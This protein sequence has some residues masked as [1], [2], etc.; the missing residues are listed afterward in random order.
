MHQI[1]PGVAAAGG[2][3]TQQHHQQDD[4]SRH[5]SPHLLR[6]RLRSL[7]HLVGCSSGGENTTCQLPKHQHAW[8]AASGGGGAM[9]DGY[10]A[11]DA[12]R[13]LSYCTVS[14]M[15]TG[16]AVYE[17][18]ACP[19]L[20]GSGATLADLR[21]QRVAV[22]LLRVLLRRVTCGSDFLLPCMHSCAKPRLQQQGVPQYKRATA[23]A[24]GRAATD[25]PASSATGSQYH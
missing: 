15:L 12:G 1:P 5:I 9:P 3:G 11:Q 17:A 22:D 7:V 2:S 19:E 14:S 24:T 6:S 13:S 20:G 21:R 16:V 18:G 4:R 8:T 23:C 25:R 10:E